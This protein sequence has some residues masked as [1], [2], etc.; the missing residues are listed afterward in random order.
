V[1]GGNRLHRGGTVGPD[2]GL[3][4]LFY[5]GGCGLCQRSVRF[6]AKRDCSGQVHF[7]PLGGGAFGRLIPESMRSGLPDSLLVRRPDGTLLLRS[8]ALIHLLG[9]MGPGWRLAGALLA[10][11]P[12]GLRDGAYD[13]VAR[14]RRRVSACT[15]RPPAADPRFEA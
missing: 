12:E 10:W 4:H 8:E 11:I 2:Q 13:W 14:R 3:T 6:V 15:W 9:R 1:G 7:A 5:D